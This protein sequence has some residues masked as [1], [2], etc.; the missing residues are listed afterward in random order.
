MSTRILFVNNDG[1]GF[2]DYV[3]VDDGTTVGRFFAREM[4]NADPSAY[5]IKVN[6]VTP[7]RDQVL[8]NGDKL[9]IVP[10]KITGASQVRILFV[11]NDGGGFSDY[12]MVDEGTTVGRFFTREMRNADPSAYLIKV[13]GVTPTRDQVLVNGDKLTIVP[14]KI[15]GA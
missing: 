9:T 8:V 6:G 15:T 1:G 14:V 10:V 12:V 13:N 2:S 11:N 7:T 5:L 3:V 4:P